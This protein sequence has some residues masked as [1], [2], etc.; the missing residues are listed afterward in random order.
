MTA[1]FRFVAN[2]TE[3]DPREF[4]AQR[5]GDRLTETGFADSGRPEETHDRAVTF[6]VELADREI[7]DEPLLY[8]LQIVV[9]AVE[10][11][12]RLIE[13]EVVFAEFRPG[14]IGNRLDIADDHGILR[15]GRGNKIEPF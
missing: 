11:L 13:I 15:A 3:T 9:I 5:I 6:R 2:A 4:A 12:L 14:Q 10:D 7:F 8:L 1:N